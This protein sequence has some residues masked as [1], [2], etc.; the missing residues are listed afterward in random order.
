LTAKH[1]EQVVTQ[2]QFEVLQF[3][4]D[5]RLEQI[6]ELLAQPASGRPVDPRD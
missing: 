3:G 6:A 1:L 5:D 2:S 4:V